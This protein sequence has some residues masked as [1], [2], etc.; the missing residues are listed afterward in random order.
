MATYNRVDDA[1]G[2]MEILRHVWASHRELGDVPLLHVY[3][4]EPGWWPSAYLEDELL[5]VENERTHFRGAAKLLDAGVV[6]LPERFPSVRY[7]VVV[8]GDVWLYRPEW[9]AGVLK[10]MRDGG[11]KLASARWMIEAFTDRLL[12]SGAVRGLLPTDGLA[13]DF[14]IVDLHWALEWGMFPLQYGRFLDSYNDLLNYAQEMPFLERYLAGKY[15]GAVR[16][17]MQAKGSRKDPWGS[18]GPRRADALFELM[19]ER[20]IDPTGRTGKTH[21]GHWP[22]LGLVTAEDAETKQKVALERPELVGATLNRLRS[23]QD[24]SWFNRVSRSSFS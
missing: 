11:K 13:C 22:E 3:N 12:P 20:N 7:L 2:G 5:V 17:E 1:R 19:T 24:T 8:A 23:E 18:G 6:A 21:K 4:G 16:N 14:F 9:V 10:N 15:L